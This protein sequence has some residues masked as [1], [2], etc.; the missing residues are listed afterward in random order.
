MIRTRQL[1]LYIKH[2]HLLRQ[3]NLDNDADNRDEK[4]KANLL[5]FIES[6]K[7]TQY[8]ESI[9]SYVAVLTSTNINIYQ[10]HVNFWKYPIIAFSVE[11]E[12]CFLSNKKGMLCYVKLIL[13]PEKSFF[14]QSTTALL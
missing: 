3:T 7:N 6:R 11:S 1:L 2:H 4:I 14:E 9:F 10:I 5:K 12:S 13:W 8:K